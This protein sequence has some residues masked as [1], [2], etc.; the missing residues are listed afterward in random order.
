MVKRS[1]GL[2][3]FRRQP[4]GGLEVLIAHPGGP[5]FARRDAG[6]WSLPK[7]EYGTG[8]EPLDAACREFTEET[9]HEPPDGERIDLGSITQRSGKVV[10]AWAVAGDLDLATLHSDECEIEWPP[11]SGRRQRFPEVDRFAWA[12]PDVA[13]HR[14]VSA[15]AEFVDRLEVVLAEREGRAV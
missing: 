10:R 6:V 11:H 8:E 12:T 5:I 3:L 2:L 9:G 1:A 15:Q 7:G 13:R 14:L 4:L